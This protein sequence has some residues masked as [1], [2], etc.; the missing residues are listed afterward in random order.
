LGA[1]FLGPAGAPVARAR[2][3]GD[4]VRFRGS[5]PVTFF[6]LPLPSAKAASFCLR[7]RARP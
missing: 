4:F 7:K 6:F 5:V 1:V 2:G 3:A